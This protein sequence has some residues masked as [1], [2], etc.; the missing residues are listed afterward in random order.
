M[1][2]LEETDSFTVAKI[3]RV[4]KLKREKGGTT[5]CFTVAK[6]LRV[7]KLV[8]PTSPEIVGFTVAKILRVLKPQINRQGFST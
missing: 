3:L 6:I 8:Y 1:N 2:S 5:L 4:L 7:L